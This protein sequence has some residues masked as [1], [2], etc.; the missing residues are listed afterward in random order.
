[1]DNL[2]LFLE[3]ML[4]GIMAITYR[5]ATIEDIETLTDLTV[6]LY[7]SLPSEPD[8][9]YNP[10]PRDELF[11]EN[12]EHLSNP[13]WA[14][15]LA[16]DKDRAVG[17]SQVSIRHDHVLGTHSSPVGHLEGI[18]VCPDYRKRGIAQNL[19]SMGEDWVRDYGCAEFASDCEMKNE[20]SFAFHLRVGFVETERLIY[21]SKRL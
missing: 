19:V 11:I 13:E 16:F 2:R 6:S 1:M 7:D 18:Y 9:D 4:E 14:I 8:D 10:Y 3:N 15:F 20:D 17:F 21:F 12:T 5:A